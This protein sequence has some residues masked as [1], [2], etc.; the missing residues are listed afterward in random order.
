MTE[1]LSPAGNY[2]KFLSAVR[3]GADAVYLAGKTFG[4]RT[5]AENFTDEELSSA[6]KYAH[7]LGRRV[8]VTVNTCR[9][10]TNIRCLKN[11]LRGW[12]ISPPTR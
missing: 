2:E 9:A 11:T 10:R 6:V 8:Y 3:F 12:E 7:G 5:A 4:M 1:L